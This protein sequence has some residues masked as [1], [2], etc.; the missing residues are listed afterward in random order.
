MSVKSSLHEM[1]HNKTIHSTTIDRN[2]EIVQ[3][4]KELVYNSTSISI[5]ESRYRL[6]VK[7]LRELSSL[8]DLAEIEANK[9]TVFNQAID[10]S[11]AKALEHAKTLKTPKG[12]EQAIQRKQTDD[13]NVLVS[14]GL[15]NECI[16]HLYQAYSEAMSMVKAL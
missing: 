14:K 8:D 11:C 7:K 9:I 15:P 3:D 2:F 13:L 16:N 5:V 4:C 10:R 12:R 6:L 1:S